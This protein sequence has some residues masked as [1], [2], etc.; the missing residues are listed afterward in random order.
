ME[1]ISEDSSGGMVKDAAYRCGDRVVTP[2]V[3][4]IT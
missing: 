4:I 2:D 3:T 1:V